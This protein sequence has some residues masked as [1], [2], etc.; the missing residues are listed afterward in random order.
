MGLSARIVC[1]CLPVILFLLPLAAR[2]GTPGEVKNLEVTAYDPATG[3]I[4][5]SFDPACGAADHHIEYGPLEDVRT[6]SYSGQDCGIGTSGVYDQFNPGPGSYFFILVGDD[7]VSVEGSYGFSM[8]N[9]VMSERPEN[10]LDPI[11]SMVQDLT[12]SCDVVRIDVVESIGVADGSQVLPSVLIDVT[13]IIGVADGS[14]VLRPILIDVT[15]NIGVNDAPAPEPSIFVVVAETINVADA[16]IVLPPVLVDVTESIGVA[17]G[18]QVLQPILIDVTEVIGVA[19]SP[20]TEEMGS[21]SRTGA[22]VTGAGDLNQDGMNDWLAGAPSYQATGGLIEAGA[23]AVYFGS[24]DPAERI[25]ADLIFE[26]AAAHDRAGVSV[27][28]NFDFNGDGKPDIMIGAEQVNR[29]RDHD[30][31]AGC[32]AGAPCGAGKVYLIYFDPNDPAFS[33]SPLRLADV[34]VTIPGVV[35]EGA[36]LGDQA[37]FAVAGAGWINAGSGQ[38]ILIGA[39]GRDTSCGNDTGA[40]YAIFDAPALSGTVRLDKVACTHSA[41]PCPVGGEIAGVVY[42]GAAAGD[43]LGFSTAFVGG[44]VRNPG[45][46]LSLSDGDIGMGAP[47]SDSGG[48]ESGTVYVADTGYA[49]IDTDTVKVSSI[50]ATTAGIQ[51]RGTQVGEHLGWVIGAGGDSRSD[52]VPDMLI[53]APSYNVGLRID[54]GRVIH[55]SEAFVTG[56]FQADDVGGTIGGV[57]W[58][59]AAEQDNLGLALDGVGDVT[60]DGFDDVVLGAPFT[61]PVVG[62][63]VRADAGSAYLIEGLRASGGAGTVSVSEIGVSVAGEELVGNEAGEHVGSSIADTSDIDANG[64][65]DFIVGAPDRDSSSGDPDAGR[66]YLVLDSEPEQVSSCGPEGCTADDRDPRSR[67]FSDSVRTAHIPIR[68]NLASRIPRGETPDLNFFKSARRVDPWIRVGSVVRY[69][70]PDFDSRTCRQPILETP[71]KTIPAYR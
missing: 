63:R 25:T 2:A 43:R 26:G 48:S 40:V 56:I 39:P 14:Q 34:G 52:G 58:L 15:E 8:I 65:A 60:A 41:V 70:Y 59:G 21:L 3:R 37:G 13:E 6:Y 53:G 45:A 67:K 64:D 71:A 5:L 44:V 19:D 22:S 18:P 11:C 24:E 32:D 55:T 16:P 4:S 30:P 28:G 33:S 9:G 69:C 36:A 10:T 47:G 7:G 29:T 50:G 1:K 27:S 46:D 62:A 42:E 57:I 54:A 38:D 66:V 12:Q 17:D 61:D 35:F 31:G 68:Q 23:V 49:A 51:I 20:A